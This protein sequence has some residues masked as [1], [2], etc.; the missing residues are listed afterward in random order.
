MNK[1]TKPKVLFLNWELNKTKLEDLTVTKSITDLLVDKKGIKYISYYD[2]DKIMVEAGGAPFTYC[3]QYSS[4]NPSDR[5]I[6]VKNE[7]IEYMDIKDENVFDWDEGWNYMN[8]DG[9]FNWKDV[10]CRLSKLAANEFQIKYIKTINSDIL[11][12][13]DWV[14]HKLDTI[15]N[16][17]FDILFSSDD[18]NHTICNQNFSEY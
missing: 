15:T 4:H 9:W 17:N 11:I 10:G 14:L 13:F 5:W 3:F 8:N 12:P 6:F 18:W 1:E 2:I 16:Y 7:L